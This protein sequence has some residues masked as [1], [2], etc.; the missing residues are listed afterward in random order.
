MTCQC[1]FLSSF[2]KAGAWL[3]LGGLLMTLT[4][5]GAMAAPVTL[6]VESDKVVRH[7]ADRF[8]GV[9]LNYIRD[10][11]A[12]RAGARPLDAALLDLGVR[13]LR[14]PGGEKSDFHLWAQPPYDVP[15]PVSFGGYAKFAGTRMDFDAYIAHC[16]AAHA[17]PYVV[18]GYDTE[19]R[20]GR[21]E[22]QWLESA[23]AWVRYANIK[24]KYGVHYWEIG[25]ENWNN[26]KATPQEMAGI[27]SRFSR[28]MKAV[29]PSVKIG[30]SGN[31]QQWWAAFLPTAA[32][33]LDF[34]S[35][36]LYNC[37]EWKGYDHFVRHPDED[38]IGDVKTA[39]KAIDHDAP[40][41]DRARLKVIVAETN[42]KDYSDKGWPGT[43]TLG[44]TLVTFDTLG[45]VMAQ[46]RVLAAMVW[47]TR[48]MDDGEAKSSQW[49]ALGPSNETLP[50]GRAIALWGQ[51]AQS[52]MLAVSGGVGGV[53]GYASRS[54]DGG[55]L[56][57]WVLNR[58][59]APADDVRIALHASVSYR[60]ATVYQLSGTGPDDP[61]PRWGPLRTRAVTENGVSGLS[62]P[63]V[64]V[65]VLVLRTAPP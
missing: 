36:S 30:A 17:E 56:T 22:A 35:L 63:G 18:V 32:P 48:W 1:S 65:T 44:H 46:P 24:K 9:N 4:P 8:V 52:E 50:T 28:A 59:L 54:P 42:S 37:W 20:T 31:S 12:N 40:P 43:N 58:D 45:R 34:L 60:R 10:A 3:A 47:T 2:Q 51:F 21:T 62:C 7:G 19:K 33:A 64:S 57:V 49:Y 61:N 39:L 41:A 13:W 23:A 27:V 6:T 26:G 5:K 14:Y 16:R 55:T 38:T 25:N 53:S 11:D 29:D 15:H